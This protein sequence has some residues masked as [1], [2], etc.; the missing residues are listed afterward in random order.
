MSAKPQERISE[1]GYRREEK[2]PEVILYRLPM[3]E[4]VPM[5]VVDCTRVNDVF[6][7]SVRPRGRRKGTVQPANNRVFY[8]A[9]PGCVVLEHFYF[10]FYNLSVL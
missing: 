2:L 1:K 6:E 4:N 5:D 9:P 3:L 10:Y 7:V 8:L